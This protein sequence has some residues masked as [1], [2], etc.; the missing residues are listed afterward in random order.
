VYQ[1]TSAHEAAVRIADDQLH[2][3]P[4]AGEQTTQESQ[5]ACAVFRRG[6]LHPDEG[7]RPRVQGPA[8]KRLH[9]RIQDL[10]QLGDLAWGDALATE[11]LDGLFDPP[12]R[13]AQRRE[14]RK[15]L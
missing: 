6:D 2:P 8:S 10:R 4:A 1:S 15:P 12:R 14:K 9:L 3:G 11:L 7:V 5:P 13:D